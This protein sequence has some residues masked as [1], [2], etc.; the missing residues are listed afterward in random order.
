MASIWYDTVID[1]R[2]EIPTD[3]A[4]FLYI[5]HLCSLFLETHF[6]EF[7]IIIKIANAKSVTYGRI[8]FCISLCRNFIVFSFLHPL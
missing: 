1:L 3:P 7:I 6:L 8:S 5:F 2:T 4:G